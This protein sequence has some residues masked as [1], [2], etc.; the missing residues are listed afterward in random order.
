MKL[1]QQQVAEAFSNGRFSETYPYLAEKIRWEIINDKILEGKNTVIGN[2]EQIAAY[3]KTVT[4]D[5]KVLNSISAGNV[6]VVNGTAVFTTTKNK[7]TE[8][9]ACDMYRF[10]DGL[11]CEITSYCIELNKQITV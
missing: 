5:F 6:V 7:R 9:A 4:T 10:E 11:L 3:F 1:I 2:C 8:V